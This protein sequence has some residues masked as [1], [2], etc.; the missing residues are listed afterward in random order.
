MCRQI[1]SETASECV[2]CPG[3]IV[4]ILQWIGAGTEKFIFTEEQ[5]PVFPFFDGDVTRSITT[6]FSTGAN[7]TGFVGHL[8]RLA[9]VQNQQVDS[10]QQGIE[11]GARGFDPKIHRVGDDK[12]R[13]L[14]LIEDVGLQLGRD[15]C[16]QDEGCSA[17]IC[18]KFGGK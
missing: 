3:R 1:T 17:I 13:P 8:A 4:N 18:G 16:Q 12:T 10:R 11:I 6:N 14:H 9:I 7:Q 15:V 5:S 2:P